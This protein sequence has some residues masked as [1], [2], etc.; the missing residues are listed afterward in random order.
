MNDKDR[1]RMDDEK[2]RISGV[3]AWCGEKI[4]VQIFKNTMFCC[5][6]HRKELIKAGRLKGTV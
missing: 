3:C 2:A 5:D 6:D 1:Q 4:L